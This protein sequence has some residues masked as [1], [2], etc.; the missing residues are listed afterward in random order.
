MSGVRIVNELLLSLGLTLPGFVDRGKVIASL[1]S[2]GLLTIAG[3]TPDHWDIEYV[4][5]DALPDD[6]LA[7]HQADLVA[8]SSLSAR[9]ADAYKIADAWRSRGVSVV[10]GGLHVSACP[11][12]ALQHADAVIV[13][14][15]EAVW[16]QVVQDFESGSMQTKYFG[17]LEPEQFDATPLPRWDLLDTDTYHRVTLQTTRGCPL[18]CAFCGAS[19]LISPYR[20]K[21]PNR[22]QRELAAIRGHWTKAFLELADDNTFVDK[23]WAKAM[24]P[25]LGGH[26]FRWFTETDISVA[27]DDELLKLLADSGCAQVLIGLESPNR[28]SLLETDSKQWKARR[29]EHVYDKIERIQR[30][31]ISV[32][33]CFIVGFDHDEPDCFENLA[34]FI[35]ASP[36]TEVQVTILTPFPGTALYQRLLNQGRLLDPTAWNKCT[37][38][39]VNFVPA[40]M[41]PSE[42]EAGF[43]DLIQS[44]YS[45]ESSRK[46]EAN[47]LGLLRASKNQK[48]T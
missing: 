6:L 17:R 18:D 13:G 15:G 2:L 42:L 45:P 1:P 35:E 11:D 7:S 33:G 43:A 5:V 16:S 8:I 31:G 10:L 26:G 47:R 22:I 44:V 29:L 12:E 21:S 34:N 24:V 30:R 25:L 41:T 20:K 48:T 39:D 32:N 19:R 36:L 46:R 4:D 14:E 27:D 38:F 40:Q 28:K 23:A 37:L 9:I 3:C